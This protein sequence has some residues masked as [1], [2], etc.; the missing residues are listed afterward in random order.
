MR[1]EL[2]L[3]FTLLC[4]TQKSLITAWGVLNEK[5]RG[6][7]ATPSVFIIGRDQRVQF[8]SVDRMGAR[9]TA[10]AVV[11][12]LAGGMKID[13]EISRRRVFPRPK[14]WFRAIRDAKR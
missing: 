11:S 5:E 9:T 7:I 10:S 12:L 3:P 6:G 14:D 13:G 2:K 8:A 4:D 1:Q